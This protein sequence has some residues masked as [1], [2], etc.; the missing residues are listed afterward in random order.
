[1]GPTFFKAAVGS[2][3]TPGT[4]FYLDD[5][6]RDG[7]IDAALRWQSLGGVSIEGIRRV[8]K[9]LLIGCVR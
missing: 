7:E 5:A 3:P 9:G 2:K 6:F 8:D 1:L 4:R